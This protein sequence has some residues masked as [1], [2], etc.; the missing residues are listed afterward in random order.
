MFRRV[1]RLL[2][3][4]YPLAWR[5]RYGDELVATAAELDAGRERARIAMLAGVL[6]GAVHAWIDAV[7]GWRSKRVFIGLGGVTVAALAAG[8][9]VLVSPGPSGGDPVLA[10]ARGNSAISR[11]QLRA[12]VVRLCG[13][14]TASK[15]VTFIDMNPDTGRVLAKATHI[16]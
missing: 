12:D 3:K 14:M 16:C 2:V 1:M 15:R 11:Q 7:G 8:L 10:A 9:V 4:A 5:R 13:P 6:A